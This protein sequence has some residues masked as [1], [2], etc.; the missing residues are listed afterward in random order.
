MSPLIAAAEELVWLRQLGVIAAAADGKVQKGEKALQGGVHPESRRGSKD[1]KDSFCAPCEWPE[2]D[3][4]DAL[5]QGL[6]PGLTSSYADPP[7]EQSQEQHLVVQRAPNRRS[8]LLTA[9]E[10]ES[11]LYA[12][13]SKDGTRF[14]FFPVQN[15]EPA[16]AAGPSFVLQGNASRDAWTLH[17]AMCQRCQLRGRSSCGRRLLA[18][19]VHYSDEVGPQK[20]LC[21][22]LEIPA[23]AIDGSCSATCPNCSDATA[24]PKMARFTTRRPKWHAT[25][26]CLTMDFR[27]R[28]ALA[29]SKNFQLEP[30]Q[31]LRKELKEQSK[32]D[33]KKDAKPVKALFG[34]ADS[35]KFVLDYSNPLSMIQAFGAALSASHWK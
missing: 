29:S 5:E 34:K 4:A 15:G 25:R 16:C 2:F 27:G 19:M 17:S 7:H 18:R 8:Y 35:D 32:L 6:G 24:P 9:P 31:D 21:M 3:L 30:A 20:A 11:L 13:V 26:Q 14:D 33:G 28:V 23:V 12:R 10:G 22:D 1:L